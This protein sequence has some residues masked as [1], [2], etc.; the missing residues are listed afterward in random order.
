M[1][2]TTSE[3]GRSW[4]RSDLQKKELLDVAVEVELRSE[5]DEVGTGSSGVWCSGQLARASGVETMSVDLVT[6][7]TDPFKRRPG[8][9]RCPRHCSAE[10]R[11][12][13]PGNR[14]RRVWSVSAYSRT[15]AIRPARTVKTAPHWLA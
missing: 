1:R 14:T 13:Q 2:N 6:H 4:W 5:V 3:A 8:P 12:A 9:I 10:V 11:N 7:R 15:A